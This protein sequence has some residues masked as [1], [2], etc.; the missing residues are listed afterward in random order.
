VGIRFISAK[1][2]R[3][4][5]RSAKLATCAAMAGTFPQ[6]HRALLAGRVK[7]LDSMK[8]LAASTGIQWQTLASCMTGEEAD[9]RLRA[10]VE[11]A[12]QLGIRSTPAFIGPNGIHIGVATLADLERISG[13]SQ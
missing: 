12:Q 1:V 6:S 7:D 11:I 2:L 13:V 9:S 8:K 5:D 10:D 3:N 4:T